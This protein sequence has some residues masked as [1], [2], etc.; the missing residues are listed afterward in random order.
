MLERRS[1]SKSPYVFTDDSESGP[2]STYTLESQRSRVRSTLRLTGCVIH[3]FRHTFGTRLGE[4]GADAFTIMRIVGHSSVTVSQKY[5]HPAPEAME[6]AF[7]RL[8]ALN[9]TAAGK[10]AESNKSTAACYSFRYSGKLNRIV[11]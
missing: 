8:E 11:A 2:L 9:Q 4:A 7:E 3:S 6:R 5:V 10:L 1:E